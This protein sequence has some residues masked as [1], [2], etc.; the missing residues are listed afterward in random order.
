M[1][2]KNST[3]ILKVWYFTKFLLNIDTILQSKFIIEIPRGLN[4]EFNIFVYN[5]RTRIN[6]SQTNFNFGIQVITVKNK[7]SLFSKKNSLYN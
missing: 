1:V 3:E 7:N 6:I 4:K 5:Y 2:N